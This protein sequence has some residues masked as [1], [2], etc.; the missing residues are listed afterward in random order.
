MFTYIDTDYYLNH[1]AMMA[2]TSLYI[3][4]WKYTT[5]PAILFMAYTSNKIRQAG[6][7]AQATTGTS[8]ITK[9]D[10]L[11]PL[12]VAAG[13]FIMF[14][15]K[16][17]SYNDAEFEWNKLFWFGEAL[18]MTMFCLNTV[19]AKEGSSLRPSIGLGIAFYIVFSLIALYIRGKGWRY[20]TF[21]S[22]ELVCA[23]VAVLVFPVME[24]IMETIVDEKM[25]KIGDRVRMYSKVMED[26]HKKQIEELERRLAEA[27]DKGASVPASPSTPSS[28]AHVELD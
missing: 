18:V 25:R 28:S 17:D 4:K 10:I 16:S 7:E 22:I 6:K 2:V 8:P 15:A 19:T 23:L 9:Y 1:A 5:I 26:N 12:L 11:S 14:Y 20:I 13:V 27:G 24:M 3:T 21:L